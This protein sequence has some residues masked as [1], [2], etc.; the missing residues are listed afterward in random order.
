M[1][2]FRYNF[3]KYTEKC[4]EKMRALVKNATTQP[5]SKRSVFLSQFAL[6]LVV[7]GFL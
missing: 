3:K 7:V 4:G 5:K 2:Q 1:A 6:L